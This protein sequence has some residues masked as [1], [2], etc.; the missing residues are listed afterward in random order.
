MASALATLGNGH[1]FHRFF[2]LAVF[3]AI[4]AGYVLLAGSLAS[5]LGSSNGGPGPTT[6]QPQICQCRSRDEPEV[7]LDAAAADLQWTSVRAPTAEN[8]S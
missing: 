7:P 3:A 4:T 8:C 6:E 2:D 5:V 1:R